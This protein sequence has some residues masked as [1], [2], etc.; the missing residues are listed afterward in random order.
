M[1]KE[2]KGLDE[3][4]ITIRRELQDEFWKLAPYHESLLRQRS[5]SRWLKEGDNNSNFFS[6]GGE[7]EKKKKCNERIDVD[8]IIEMK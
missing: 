5:R 4:G 8:N 7:L 6:C 1:S 3:G 2:M